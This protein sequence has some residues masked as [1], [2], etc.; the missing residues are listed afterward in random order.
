MNKHQIRV[1]AEAGVRPRIEAIERELAL[2]HKEWPEI[3]LTPTAPQLLKAKRRNG[4][5]NG[6]GHWPPVLAPEETPAPTTHRKARRAVQTG[7]HTRQKLATRE[8]SARRLAVLE[9]QGPLT[10]E[11]WRAATGG[12]RI[13]IS[14]YLNNGLVKRLRGAKLARTS[15][16]FVV[17]W[18]PGAGSQSS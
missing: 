1:L 12:G 11:A 8:E 3:F 10:L 5:E 17:K 4:H 18:T 6:N 14:P 13:A 2:Y 9:E 16:P 15:K 7:E